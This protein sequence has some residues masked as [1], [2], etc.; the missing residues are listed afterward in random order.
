M[1]D[2]KIGQQI[3]KARME[4]QIT[5]GELGK[6]IGVTWEMISRYENGKSSPRRNLEKISEV[7]SKPI[8]FFFGVE[9]A[10]ISEEISRL[11]Q[12]LEKKKKDLETDT[13]IPMIDTMAGLSLNEALKLTSQKYSCPMWIQTNYPGVF[14]LKLDE[15][16]SAIVSTGV[17]N[18]GFFSRIKARPGDYILI[19]KKG[20]LVID[21]MSNDI[22][23]NMIAVLLAVEK[24]YHTNKDS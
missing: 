17:S 10:P 13:N 21:K 1:S 8:Q 22:D 20:D 15:V 5:Q 14:A 12:L 3:R 19:Q 9:E 7:L 6:K 4:K 2:L 16:E 18:V 23:G 11:Y 24:R